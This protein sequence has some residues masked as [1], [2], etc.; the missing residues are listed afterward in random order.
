M[1]LASGRDIDIEERANTAVTNVKGQQI[2]PDDTPVFHPAFDV[3]PAQ[4][5]SALITE[6][7]IVYPP[8][9][10][11]LKRLMKS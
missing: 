5:V 3:T 1:S 2:T 11:N 8:Y 7:G 4:Y 6:K 9:T 10:E